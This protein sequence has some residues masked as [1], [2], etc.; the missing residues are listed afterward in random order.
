[1]ISLKPRIR[2]FAAHAALEPAQRGRLVGVLLTWFACCACSSAPNQPDDRVWVSRH[3]RYHTRSDDT[4][5]AAVTDTLELEAAN[6]INRFQLP[7][8]DNWVVDYY[9]Y[10]DPGDLK[11]SG[12]CPERATACSSGRTVWSYA[13]V[14]RH[15]LTHAYFSVVGRSHPILEE[16][17][18][19]AFA[20]EI[21]P[22]TPSSSTP[23]N[24]AFD[25]SYE[26]LTGELYTEAGRFAAFLVNE[27]GP[28]P[29]VELYESVAHDA[30]SES[31][32]LVFQSIYGALLADVWQAAAAAQPEFGCLRWSECIGPAIALSDWQELGVDCSY[33]DT[34]RTL[35]TTTRQSF[36]FQT[37]AGSSSRLV[38]CD[39]NQPAA[40]EA[41]AD[42]SDAFALALGPGSYFAGSPSP[43]WPVYVDALPGGL[44]APCANVAA[45][46]VLDFDSG[47]TVL[48]DD[49]DSEWLRFAGLDLLPG[50][51]I[52][53]APPLVRVW[54]CEGCDDA[55]CRELATGVQDATVA[56]SA[57]LT[58]LLQASA[59]APEDR[60]VRISAG[61]NQP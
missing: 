7:F 38:S 61:T 49:S 33:G 36:L 40:S 32:A 35:A 45:L 23:W 54:A 5:C 41:H 17:I 22:R 4:A 20:C 26:N 8:A 14:D 37:L 1:L 10:T 9:K 50:N 13:G 30:S 28:A 27:Y 19:E 60:W 57:E 6:V 24:A 55:N 39:P 44:A 25:T 12:I 58:F 52:V 53:R 42:D 31:A 47:V 48:A 3:F 34:F 15:E 11:S 16:G 2:L 43:G 29:F 56:P 59:A 18:A 21:V 46:G 51:L